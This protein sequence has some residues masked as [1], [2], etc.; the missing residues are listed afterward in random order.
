M[1]TLVG[2]FFILLGA[3]LTFGSRQLAERV[4]RSNAAFLGNDRLSGP[5]WR[6][7]N[8]SVSVLIGVV[9]MAAG[10][11]MVFGVLVFGNG[12]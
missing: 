4:M 8:T 9:F 3:A 12:P 7:W 10:V 2:I 6:A 11:A 5:G 1:E